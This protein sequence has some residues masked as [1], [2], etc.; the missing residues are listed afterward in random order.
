MPGKPSA[1]SSPS[2]ASQPGLFKK[3][4]ILWDRN[5]HKSDAGPVSDLTWEPQ[6]HPNNLAIPVIYNRSCHGLTMASMPLRCFTSNRFKRD[7]TEWIAGS[8]PAMT[9]FL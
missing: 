2:A 6:V 5:C 8:S 9:K 1:L 7:F 4:T 3:K